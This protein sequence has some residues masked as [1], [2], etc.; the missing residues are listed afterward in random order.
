MLL[1][2][3]KSSELESSALPLLLMKPEW[4]NSTWSKC[5]SPLMEQS[6]TSW[7]EQSS[8]SP[9]C[10]RTFLSWF[11]A[12]PNPLSLADTLSEISTKLLTTWSNRLASSKWNSF[13]LT[14][15]RNKSW[16][17][18]TSKTVVSSWECITLMSQS[19]ALLMLLSSMLSKGTT[20]FIWVPRTPFLRSTMAD[21]KISSKIYMTTSI[22]PNSKRRNFGTNTDLLTTWLLML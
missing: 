7:T 19:Q 8:E 5:G 4:R 1:K 14:D 22:N 16:M 2:P 13:L 6:G 11:L 9:F 3:L 10:A 17:Y 15:Q 20:L 21:S 12:G 18:S